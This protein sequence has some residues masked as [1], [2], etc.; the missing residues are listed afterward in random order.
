MIQKNWGDLREARREIGISM[1]YEDRV[2]EFLTPVTQA[3]IHSYLP[4][5]EETCLN[6]L[7]AL[8]HRIRA[9]EDD[10]KKRGKELDANQ[11]RL[12]NRMLVLAGNVHFIGQ[13]FDQALAQYT[14]AIACQSN[15]YYALV[16]AAQ[17]EQ[18]LGDPN[19]AKKH[20][21]ACLEAIE[22][23]NDFRRKREPSRQ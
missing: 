18:N 4:G 22:R 17:C 11:R 5:D 13:E 12:R 15:D 9:V 19:S 10:V 6:E 7:T 20:F 2:G 21:A 8:L 16:S 1:S 14:Q 23:S 3:E